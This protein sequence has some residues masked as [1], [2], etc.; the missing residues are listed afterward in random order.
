MSDAQTIRIPADEMQLLFTAVLLKYGFTNEKAAQCAEV[1]TSNS[2]DGVYTHGFNRFPVFVQYVK[3]GLVDKDAESSLDSAFNAIEQWNGNL[4][5]GPL[6]A[7]HATGRAVQLAQ[8][9]GIGCVALADTN[10]WMRGG[11][12]GWQ[13]AKKGCVFIGWSNT[14]ANMPAWGAVDAKLGNNPLVIALPY[15][16]E[17]IVLDMA[18]SQ[19]SFGTLEIAKAKDET[20]PVNGG[21]D[22]EGKLTTDPAAIIQSQRPL[23]IGYWKGAGLSLLLDIL[24]AILSGGLATH[25]I[26]SLHK[27]HRLSQVFICIDITKLG[28]HSIIAQT[29]K[30]IIDDYHQS[31][32]TEGGK[33]IRFPGERVLHTRKENRL[34]GIPVLQSKWMEIQKL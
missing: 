12:Y 25:Q 24:A 6:N 16:G 33:K 1:F 4:G 28:N 18:M 14:I 20:L 31:Q 22:K 7:I 30:T 13:A 15:E 23:P 5:P 10:H 21:Y 27:E 11:Y 9:H 29:V 8:S 17:A 32:T 19:Y 3:E 2:I 34:N 26:S